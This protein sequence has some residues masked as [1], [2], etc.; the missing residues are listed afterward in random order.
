M[1]YYVHAI[2]STAEIPACNLEEAYTVLC[3]LNAHNDLKIEG[4]YRTPIERPADSKSLSTDPNRWF[5]K[6]PWNYDEQCHN[7]AE[8]LDLI[9]FYADYRPDG[10]LWFYEYEQQTGQE[11]LFIRAIAHLVKPGTYIR[12]I[13]EE[14]QL[15][16][17]VFNG[18]GSDVVEL[19]G[20]A[21]Y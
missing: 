15:W 2:D 1:G 8:V 14:D 13:G 19:V 21:P 7:A 10:S 6:M 16:D 18:T 3:E 4:H 12:W 5:S 20:D 9:G 11:V 17:W